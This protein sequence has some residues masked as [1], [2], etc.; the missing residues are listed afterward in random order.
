[1]KKKIL[2]FQSDLYTLLIMFTCSFFLFFPIFFSIKGII[3]IPWLLISLFINFIVNLIN[4]NHSH[5]PT[6]GMS[7]L[8]KL[9][10]FH[11]TLNRG[12]SASFI[13]I[14]H[15]LNHHKYAGSEE[16]WF[17]PLNEGNGE[18]IYR[19]FVYV[20]QTVKKFRLGAKPF[21]QKMGND[22]IRQMKIENIILVIFIISLLWLNWQAFLIFV[23]VPWYFGNMF[24]VLTN[25]IFHKGTSPSDQYNLSLNFLNSLENKLFLNGGYHTAH[26]L[27]PHIHWSQLPQLHE[28]E[29][30]SKIDQ[31]FIKDSMFVHLATSYF[32]VGKKYEV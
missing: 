24:L 26:H 12:A 27:K 32:I 8:N 16:D 5:V 15:N 30:A 6:F 13:K 21:Y 9:F 18:L 10:E 7:W 17:S 28:N 31:K 4:H 2:P 23:L 3:I 11:L 22:F 25:L 29:V 14:I 20:K 1:M 19:P